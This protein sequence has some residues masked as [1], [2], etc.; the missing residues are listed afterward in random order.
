MI[1]VGTAQ[2]LADAILQFAG[3]EQARGLDD[4]ALGMDPVRLDRIEPWAFD[5]QGARED[6]HALPLALDLEIPVADPG[7]DGAADL[8]GGVVPDQEQDGLALRFELGAAPAQERGRHRAERPAVDEAQPGLLG[9]VHRADQEPVGGQ[10][11]GVRIVL[12]DGLLDQAQ[13][14]IGRRPSMHRGRGGPPP[15][16]LVLE[17]QG[18][19]RVRRQEADQAIARPF[20]RAYAGSGLVIHSLARCQRIS[21]RARVARMVSPVTR[22]AVTP[23]SKLTSA[24]SSKVHRLVGLPK[25]RGL[26]WSIALS[27]SARAASKD[28]WMVW[29]REEATS[30]QASPRALKATMALRTVWSSQPRSV[31]ISRAFLRRA[32]ASRIWQRRRTKASG[33]RRPATTWSCSSAVSS[34]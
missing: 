23:R 31:A 15:P 12:G 20:F 26:W 19:G 9:R 2:S 7:A 30:R 3:G 4:L 18:P 27:C 33:E 32:E 13:G 34:R 29:G 21:R 11:L 6:A 14:R 1:F 16:G 17:A 24:A 10:G 5:R 28:A 8:P 25:A 22:S